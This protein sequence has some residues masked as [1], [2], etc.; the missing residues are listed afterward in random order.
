MG[1]PRLRLTVTDLARGDPHGPEWNGHGAELDDLRRTFRRKAFVARQDRV[2]RT[3]LAAGHTPEGLAGMRL[4]ELD[5]SPELD[6]YRSRRAELGIAV[7]DGA[8]LLV[9]ADGHPVE[10]ADAVDL[11]RRGRTTRVS[12]EGNACFCRGLLA[13]RYPESHPPLTSSTS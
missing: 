9:R 12:I 10:P 6:L 3:L 1:T 4:G 2:A 7:D 5:G 13:T 11:L 8:P